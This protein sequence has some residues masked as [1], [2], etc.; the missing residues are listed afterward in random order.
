VTFKS[1]IKKTHNLSNLSYL[2]KLIK[3]IYLPCRGARNFLTA[4]TLI[5]RVA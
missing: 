2:S 1:T 3:L 4:S 5:S